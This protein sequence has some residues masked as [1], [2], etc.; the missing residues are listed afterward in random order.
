MA[1][2]WSC[3]FELNSTAANMEI[4]GSS[5][6]GGATT[7]ISTAQPFSGAYATRHANAGASGASQMFYTFTSADGNGPF[8]ARGYL[9]VTD[10]PNAQT[11]IF[12]YLTGA[13]SARGGIRLNADG[14]LALYD[15]AGA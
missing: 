7:T 13:A 6:G 3:G 14:S 8:Y 4:S 11:Q 15:G 9:Y 5:S 1:R 12:Y 2:L 10:L